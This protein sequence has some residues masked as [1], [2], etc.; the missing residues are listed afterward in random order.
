MRE[1]FGKITRNLRFDFTEFLPLRTKAP[2]ER[3]AIV[4]GV[5]G[6]ALICPLAGDLD[7]GPDSL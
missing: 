5:V 2:A 7:S 3:A 1:K 4:N 6:A